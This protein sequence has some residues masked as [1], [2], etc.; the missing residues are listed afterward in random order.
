MGVSAWTDLGEWIE[1]APETGRKGSS[2][3]V[4]GEGVT[5]SHV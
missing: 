4:A 1:E 2:Q 3:R 5:G